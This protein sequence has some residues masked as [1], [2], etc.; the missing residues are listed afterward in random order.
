MDSPS[1]EE[2]MTPGLKHSA[3]G[4]RAVLHLH[5]NELQRHQII[6]QDST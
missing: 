5:R 6:E 3:G 2:A 4:S 1:Q